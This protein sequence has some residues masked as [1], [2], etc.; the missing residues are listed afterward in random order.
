VKALEMVAPGTALRE[1][2]DNIVHA[3]T[4]GL[5]VVGDADDLA[6]L[7]SGGLK[8]DIDY[9]PAFLYQLAKMDGALVL[10]ANATK[11][12]WANVQ[13]TPHRRSSRSRPARATAPPSASPSRPRRS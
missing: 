9:T 10:S 2:I 4:G 7:F 12:V 11:I 13:R 8:L 3:R 6:F 1:G 5:I